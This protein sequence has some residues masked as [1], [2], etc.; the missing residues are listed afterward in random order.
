MDS[1]SLFSGDNLMSCGIILDSNLRPVCSTSL[2]TVDHIVA[3]CVE[4]RG[5]PID[6]RIVRCH[7]G[8]VGQVAFVPQVDMYNWF[9]NN[10]TFSV[11]S[12]RKLI[13]DHQN[14]CVASRTR[15]IKFFPIKV[16]ILAWKV[17]MNALPT[18]FNMSRRGLHIVSLACPICDNN[19]ETTSHLFFQCSQTHQL[20]KLIARWW[21]VE[22]VDFNSYEDWLSWIVSIRIPSKLKAIL[23]G[24]FYVMW[25]SIWSFRN[26][27]LFS[28]KIPQKAT[29]FDDIVSSSFHCCEIHNIMSSDPNHEWEQLLDIDDSDIPLTPV[30]RP[31]NSHVRETITAT[32]TQ[33]PAVDNFEEKPVRIIPV[34]MGIVQLAKLRKQSD[35]HEGGDESVLSTKEYMK[36][37]VEDVGEDEDFKSG[38]WVS[39]TE[40][41]NANGGIVSGCLGDINNFLKNGKLE[42][43]VAI[44][45]SCTPNALG[46]LT[47]TMKDISCIIPGAI[48]HKV[49][50]EGGY[51]KDITVGSALILANVSVFSP[52]P[53]MHY[54]NITMRNVVKIFYKDSVPVNGS[55]VGG[56]GM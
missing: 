27:L 1:G 26:K 48:H 34:L 12:M 23:E 25:W 4:L 19:P 42:Q 29:L 38:S 44:I 14:P 16:N 51:G 40:Y 37:V 15:W 53:S 54:L 11:A 21:D 10:G 55:G 32:T 13:D 28:G 33:N 30:L 31:W 22:L 41:V 47:V 45:K 6:E 43:I 49:I 9:P 3:N 46:D 7:V 52:K 18:R 39:A 8:T 5:F 2:E 17:K 20:Y 35:I 36:K 56:S 24:V 50:N